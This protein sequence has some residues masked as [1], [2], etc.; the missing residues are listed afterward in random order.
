LIQKI[1]YFFIYLLFGATILYSRNTPT[2][3]NSF[4]ANFKQIITSDSGKKI[5]YD[6]SILFS[7]PKQ[8]KWIY[9]SPTKK[10]ICTDAVELIVVDHDLE[11]VSKFI[12]DRGLN[13]SAILTNAKEKRKSVYIASYGGKSYTIQVDTKNRLSRIAYRD[14]LDNNVLIIFSHMNYSKKR[15]SDKTMRCK[16]PSSYDKIEG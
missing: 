2:L 1:R 14:N 6:G 16:I 11:Q 5:S 8:F 3:P 15:Y 13:L 4:K 9:R 7:S 10:N 12:M